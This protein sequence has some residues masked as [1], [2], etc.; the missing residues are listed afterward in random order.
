LISPVQKGYACQENYFLSQ[1]S[2]SQ[3]AAI[4]DIPPTPDKS[5]LPNLRTQNQSNKNPNQGSHHDISSSDLSLQPLLNSPT[6]LW[7]FQLFIQIRETSTKMVIL[8]L[9]LIGITDGG[10]FEA[11]TV[12]VKR[13]ASWR[14]RQ[15]KWE[16]LVMAKSGYTSYF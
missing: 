16:S 6:W 5:S 1:C 8:N 2:V 10:G 9:L 13:K 7:I 14:G 15:R 12:R 11:Q 4:L 3:D